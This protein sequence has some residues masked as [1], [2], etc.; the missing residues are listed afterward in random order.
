MAGEGVKS[1]PTLWP[2]RPVYSSDSGIVVLNFQADSPKY[3]EKGN[4]TKMQWPMGP[5][6]PTALAGQGAHP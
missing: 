3:C 5:Q 4:T 6:A 2:N 1:I